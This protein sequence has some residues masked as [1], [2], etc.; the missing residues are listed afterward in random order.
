MNCEQVREVL[1]AFVNGRKSG[2]ES[3]AVRL[4]LAS[5][6]AC[7]SSLSPSER[8]EILPALD[9]EIE[10]SEDYAARFHAKLQNQKMGMLPVY[11]KEKR[12]ASPFWLSAWGRPW[13]LAALGALAMLLVAGVFLRRPGGTSNEPDNLN[14][15]AIAENLHLL[16]DMAVINNL[17]L[18]ENFDTIEKLA[19]ALESS[20]EQRSNP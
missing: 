2:E 16:Q 1:D 12:R 18:L 15:L 7:A 6:A 19:P 11:A 17:D 14:D 20:K 13:Q 3:R 8:I 4:H 9:D 10:P 5:C